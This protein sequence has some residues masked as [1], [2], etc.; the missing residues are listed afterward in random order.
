MKI[1]MTSRLTIVA[2]SIL[3]C[4]PAFAQ[5]DEARQVELQGKFD[6]KMEKPFIAYGNWLTDYDQARKIAK[7]EGKLLFVY[8]TRS[9]A[10]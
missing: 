6:Q 7:Q 3:L 5:E 1:S 9:Y 10:P 8:F 2:A 4:T